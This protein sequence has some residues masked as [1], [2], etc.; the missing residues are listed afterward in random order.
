MLK[1][2]KRLQAVSKLVRDNVSLADIGTD[3]AYLPVFLLQEGKINRAIACDI[4]ESPLKNA[5]G[6]IRENNV[7]DIELRLGDGLSPVSSYEVDDIVIAGMGAENII[8][9]LDNCAWCKG[10]RYNFVF[11]PM[12]RTELLREYLC[13]SGY[14][15]YKEICTEENSKHYCVIGAR[16]NGNCFKASEL[17]K[18]LGKVPENSDKYSKQYILFQL[19]KY[20]RILSGLNRAQNSHDTSLLLKTIKEIEEIYNDYS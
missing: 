3:H 1:L 17:F 19:N 5:A 16:Y 7:S 12:T 14:E 4:N 11:Q 18:A 8:A 2:S 6:C 10:K 15:I 13:E 20:K 9:I